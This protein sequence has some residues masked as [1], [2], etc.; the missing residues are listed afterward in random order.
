M[1]FV[2]LQKNTKKRNKK[3]DPHFKK[4]KQKKRKAEVERLSVKKKKKEGKETI[5]RYHFRNRYR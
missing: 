1:I 5:V 3:N 2:E 4:S